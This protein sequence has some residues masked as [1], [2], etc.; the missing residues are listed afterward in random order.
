[1]PMGFVLVCVLQP[2]RWLFRVLKQW[3][4]CDPVC[5]CVCVHCSSSMKRLPFSDDEFA[6][7]PAKMAREEE[8]KKG[9]RYGCML[10]SCFD[11][12]HAGF[13]EWCCT[14]WL[15]QCVCV[16]LLRLPPWRQPHSLS[17]WAMWSFEVF[18]NIHTCL[19][20]PLTPQNTTD[21]YV[22]T[23]KQAC[24]LYSISYS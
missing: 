16:C 5:F 8:P 18:Q 14:Q 17:H 24:A 21:Q 11:C 4:V 22:H 20:P 6:P 1:M 10:L 9:I 19:R 2:V 7:P 12:S 15:N 13:F 23:C 3:F